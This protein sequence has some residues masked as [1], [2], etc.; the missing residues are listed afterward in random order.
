[1]NKLKILLIGFGK[2][3]MK[4]AE[5]I[6][7]RESLE[8][9]GVLEKD[10]NMIGKDI[11]VLSGKKNTGIIISGSL[12]DILKA[13]KPDAAIISTVSDINMILESIGEILK[14]KVPV[15]STCEELLYPWKGAGA[16]AE[17]IDG[18]ARENGVAA[19][20]TGVNPGFL[21]DSYPVFLTAVC[22]RVDDIKISR[23]QDASFRRERFKHKIGAG[24]EIKEFKKMIREG[25]MGHVGL[26]ESVDMIAS[27]MNWTLDDYKETV[28]PV[29]AERD[30][31][32]KDYKI[33]KGQA[34]GIKQTG[35]GFEKGK[36]KITLIFKA[37]IGEADPFDRVEISGEP[38]IVSEIKGGINGDIATAAIVINAV[39]QITK[40]PPGL[41]TMVDIPLISYFR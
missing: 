28:A 8:I 25:K 6:L 13:K 12:E 30:I 32:D 2:V 5:F 9:I 10:H 33:K 1:M 41:R 14:F 37:S 3:G 38:D 23:I 20:G 34:A 19:I 18:L 24:L 27:R 15:V 29:I 22:Q 17:K 35:V 40:A 26:K 36:E 31:L 39:M 7:E 4:I 16:I 21:M 11:G